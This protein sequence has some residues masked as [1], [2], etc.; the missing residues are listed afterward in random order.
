MRLLFRLSSLARRI[1][2]R[3]EVD[4]DLDEEIRSQVELMTDQ[5]TK[6]GLAPDEA[7]RVARIELGGV[8]QVKEQVRAART[9]SWL[10][11]LL[12]DIRFGVRVRRLS[13]G[14]RFSRLPSESERTPRS[15]ALSTR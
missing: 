7:R 6:E 4:S 13:Q 8:E 9:G 12:Q 15:S 14:L 11:S 10:D 3:H 2:H 1:F 5:K